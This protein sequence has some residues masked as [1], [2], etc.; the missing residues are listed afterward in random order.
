MF[1]TFDQSEQALKALMLASTKL[2]LK[3]DNYSEKMAQPIKPATTGRESRA[4]PDFT[5]LTG[6]RSDGTSVPSKQRT[7][8]TL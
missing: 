6:H 5:A 2:E 7:T 4:L 3:K 1:L 8:N